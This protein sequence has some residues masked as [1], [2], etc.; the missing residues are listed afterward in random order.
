MMKK[1]LVLKSFH[2]CQIIA[3][4]FIVKTFRRDL[5]KKR[6]WLIREKKNEARDNG[7]HLFKYLREKHPQVNAYFAITDDSPDL[8]KIKHLHNIISYASW[9]HCLYSVAAFRSISSQQ[10]GAGPYVYKYIRN[11]KWLF[12]PKMREVFLQH[13][14]TQNDI[15]SMIDYKM[16]PCDLFICGTVR[17]Y[18][19]IV[20]KYAYPLDH[21]AALGFCRFDSLQYVPSP[22]KQILVMPTWRKW[23]HS[24]DSTKRAS[25]QK[26]E[27]FINSEY[28]ER[29]FNLLKNADLTKTLRENGYKIIFYPHYALQNYVS[30]FSDFL[31]ELSR[32]V[33]EIA[34][35]GEYDVQDLLLKSALLITDYSSVFFDFA[36]MKKPV[37]YYQFDEER[38]RIG[39]YEQGYFEYRRDGYGPVFTEEVQLVEELIQLIKAGMFIPEMYKKRIE[40]FFIPY[41]DCNRERNYEAILK[42]K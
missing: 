22:L 24:G 3:A 19:Y 18:Q 34:N 32:D 35:R 15:P 13:G 21:I 5:I 37:I 9:K 16:Y 11:N 8:P 27:A 25:K 42:L 28:Y 2:M 1:G 7:Y 29:Y 26:I 23:L 38:F 30:I 17:E 33:V 6:I 31:P 10:Y 12:N 14:I 40:S 39:Q 20:K 36:Y 4:S 41:D